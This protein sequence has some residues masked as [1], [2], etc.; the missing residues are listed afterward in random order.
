MGTQLEL[1]VDAAAVL[2]AALE[3]DDVGVVHDLVQL[4]FGEEL[5]RGEG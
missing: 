3:L 4:D 2:E 1:H 5:G